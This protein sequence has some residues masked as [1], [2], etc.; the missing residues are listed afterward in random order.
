MIRLVI[1]MITRLFSLCMYVSLCAESVEM[2]RALEGQFCGR[3][4][5]RPIPSFL[6]L[7]NHPLGQN[8]DAR[9]VVASKPSSNPEKR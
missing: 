9:A 5:C 1:L 7:K 4:T 6:P 8:E 2:G 3:A